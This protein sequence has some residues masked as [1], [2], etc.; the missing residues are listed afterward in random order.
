MTTGSIFGDAFNLLIDFGFLQ[1]V[2]PFIL[3]YSIVFGMLER[4]QIFSRDKEKEDKQITNLHAMIAFSIAVTATAASQAVGIT[5][6][7]LPILSVTA[8]IL[9]GIMLLLGLAFGD[10]FEKTVM[11][12]KTYKTIIFTLLGV[13][14]LGAVVVVGYYS[15]LVVTP[16]I[17]GDGLTRVNSLDITSGQCTQL[18][19]ITQF[20]QSMYIMGIE[21]ADLSSSL[22]GLV[23]I[24]VVI[25][26]V[27]LITKKTS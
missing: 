17:D 12:S 14:V 6:N 2:V 3:F 1:I 24:I 8:V 4:T 19:D 20:P 25:G 11:Q 15:G 26:L 22:I 21:M 23:G 7:Y 10:E 9:V 16:C 18:F 5:Q 13:L 27:M